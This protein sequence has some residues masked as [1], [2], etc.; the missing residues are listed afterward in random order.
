MK[1]KRIN[2]AFTLS[3]VLITLSIIGII[4]AITLPSLMQRYKRYE[5]ALKLKKFYITLNQAFLM[6]TVEYGDMEIWEFPSE[7]NNCEQAGEFVNKYL[8]PYLKGALSCSANSSD[9]MFKSLSYMLSGTIMC[10]PVYKFSDGGCFL[11]FPGGSGTTSG[12]LHL[13]YDINC[14]GNPNENNKDIFG[15]ILRWKA[16]QSFVFKGGVT[17]TLSLTERDENL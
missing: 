11:L 8:F 17:A 9:K 2:S 1:I 4:A 6:A 12:Y 13:V 10:Y 7:Q 5:V 3:E 16:N 15:F 14:E